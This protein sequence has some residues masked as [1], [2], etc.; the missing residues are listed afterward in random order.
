MPTKYKTMYE[1]FCEMFPNFKNRVTKYGQ[2]KNGAGI[3]LVL[4]DRTE[5]QFS[6]LD[7]KTWWLRTT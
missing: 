3:L 7:N 6:Y 4:D 1:T 5:L 2:A